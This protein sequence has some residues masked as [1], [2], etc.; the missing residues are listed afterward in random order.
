[1]SKILYHIPRFS[2]T[3][4]DVGSLYFTPNEMVFL[5]LNNPAPLTLNDIQIDIVDKSE[6][7][8]Q[9]LHGNTIVV[10]YIK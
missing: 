3:G 7:P 2:D 9:D 4:D 1:M 6:K 10:L 8:L 5:K